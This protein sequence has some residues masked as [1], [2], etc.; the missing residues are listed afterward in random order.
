MQPKPIPPSTLEDIADWLSVRSPDTKRLDLRRRQDNKRVDLIAW[1]AK[2][3]NVDH[4]ETA[5]RVQKACER[6]GR[7]LP[8]LT[9]L[10]DLKPFT[11]ASDG[12]GD[13]ALV[14]VVRG[15]ASGVEDIEVTDMA[16]AFVHVL[17]ENTK[18]CAMLVQSRAESDEHHLRQIQMLSQRVQEDDAR[19]IT[20]WKL[21]EDLHTAAA[22]RE[23]GKMHAALLDK[24]NKYV[25]DKLDY[26]LPIAANRLLGGGPGTGKLPA[27][28][29]MLMAMLSKMGEGRVKA[30]MKGDP[31][32]FTEDER[33]IF[34]EIYI[35]QAAE[36]DAREA[37]KRTI[38]DDAP[39]AD[40]SAA[41]GAP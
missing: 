14:V 29:Q 28:G 41:A 8:Q 31:I 30:I 36:H 16:S 39:P 18:L 2:A 10:Y 20:L 38:N 21:F 13:G 4:T 24:R 25:M 23:Q 3:A 40:A 33:A 37:K 35:S 9:V 22:E 27:V 17:K 32:A 34:A 5:K 15:A 12:E 19:R 1:T 6:D 11:D 26:Y 7:T